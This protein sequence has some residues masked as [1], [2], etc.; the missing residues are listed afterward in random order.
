VSRIVEKFDPSGIPAL[1]PYAEWI[2]LR[3]TDAET[4]RIVTRDASPDDVFT[5]FSTNRNQNTFTLSQD[6]SKLTSGT[7]VA[8]TNCAVFSYPVV[9]SLNERIK[10][11][12][13]WGV[14]F[15]IKVH[16]AT[17]SGVANDL[18]LAVGIFNGDLD[19]QGGRI[20]SGLHY[21]NNTGPRIFSAG[22]GLSVSAQQ[23][24]G[25]ADLQTCRLFVD[26]HTMPIGSNKVV[27]R[28]T[29]TAYEDNG[30]YAV[31]KTWNVVSAYD[32]SADRSNE[33]AYIKLCVGRSSA[34]AN[35]P[36]CT[37]EVYYQVREPPI[38]NGVLSN[39]PGV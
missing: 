34:N 22:K 32:T 3:F 39:A 16:S 20:A 38:Y 35:N 11:S 6:D 12:D 37:F 7:G 27:Q 19:L 10:L 14:K 29:A 4:S 9:N 28:G 13:F 1:V 33:N 8:A 24:S 18:F 31:G 15:F 5:S 2:P 17:A 21:N 26:F 30:D 36:T 23:T 25:R